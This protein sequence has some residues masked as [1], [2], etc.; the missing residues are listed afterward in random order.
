MTMLPKFLL[1]L[2]ALALSASSAGAADLARRTALGNLFSDRPVAVVERSRPVET[3]TVA[4]GF[5]RTSPKVPGYYGDRGDFFYQ[6]YYGTPRA[7]IFERLPYACVL[8]LF[9]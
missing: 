2:A 9:C 6:N 8:E 4:A 7:V 5:V 3:E 1:A